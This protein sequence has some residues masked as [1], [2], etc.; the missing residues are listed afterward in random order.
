MVSVVKYVQGS[1]K[2][3]YVIKYY[4]KKNGALVKFH[5]GESG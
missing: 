5:T 3:F 1:H 2:I 4:V